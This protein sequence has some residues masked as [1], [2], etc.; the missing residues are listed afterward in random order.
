M[1][2]A[3]AQTPAGAQVSSGQ[4]RVSELLSIGA[5]QA[6]AQKNKILHGVP[7]SLGCRSIRHMCHEAAKDLSGASH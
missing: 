5:G 3:G 2:V 6:S 1:A 4:Q 7:C